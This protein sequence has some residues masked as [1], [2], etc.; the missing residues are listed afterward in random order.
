MTPLFYLIGSKKI[1]EHG[2]KPS[3][4]WIGVGKQIQ[5]RFRIAYQLVT[6]T[7]PLACVKCGMRTVIWLWRDEGIVARRS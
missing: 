4:E 1:E 5:D 3:F 2:W 7:R 6:K